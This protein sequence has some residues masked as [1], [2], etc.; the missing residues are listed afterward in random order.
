MGHPVASPRERPMKSEAATDVRRNTIAPIA[1]LPEYWSRLSI[2]KTAA[3][4]HSGMTSNHFTP[5]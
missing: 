5:G 2:V 3:I 1:R 4:A